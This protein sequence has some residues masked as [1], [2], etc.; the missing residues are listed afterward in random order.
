MSG[1]NS[2]PQDTTQAIGFLGTAERVAQGIQDQKQSGIFGLAKHNNTITLD[3]INEQITEARGILLKSQ[4]QLPNANNNPSFGAFLIKM[5]SELPCFKL[6]YLYFLENGP[7]PVDGDEE[8]SMD[9]LTDEEKLFIAV[10]TGEAG[11]NDTAGQLAVAHTVINRTRHSRFPNTVTEVLTPDQY[12]A[13]SGNVPYNAMMNYLNNRDGEDSIKEAIID[14]LLPVYRGE[15]TDTTG[16]AVM[17]YSPNA[18]PDSDGDGVRDTPN[19]NFDELTEV[20]PDG[21]YG[22]FKFYTYD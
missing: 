8:E 21:S 12:N 5:E 20:E 1:F 9:E 7:L 3:R 6:G 22:D 16:G 17:F 13:A 19:W 11:E 18:M 4:A 10:V 14:R 2:T 15:A